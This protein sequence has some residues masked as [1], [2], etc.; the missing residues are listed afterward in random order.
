M[1]RVIAFT[2]ATHDQAAG[3]AKEINK[4]WP[5][6]HAAVYRPGDGPQYFLV[7]L[8]GL[9]TRENAVRLQRKARAEGLPRDI[10]VQNYE[11]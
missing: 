8:G 9:M 11:R 7:S 2:Y 3:K 10:Y 1:W 4:K 6:L 5:E